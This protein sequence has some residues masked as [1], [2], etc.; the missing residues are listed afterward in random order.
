[1]D[2]LFS[3]AIELR[4]SQDFDRGV[5]SEQL[6]PALGILYARQDQR[7]N[8]QIK[9]SSHDVSIFWLPNSP[10]TDTFTG[11]DDHITVRLNRLQK[12]VEVVERSC[13]I[14]IGKSDEFS[15]CR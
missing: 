15:S 7:A 14:G 10:R 12:F 11:S 6:E 3:V 8:E 4:P 2:R 1:M 13:E 5:A 9:S